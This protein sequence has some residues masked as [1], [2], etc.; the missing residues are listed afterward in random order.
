MLRT[1]ARTTVIVVLAAVVAGGLYLALRSH[2]AP[3]PDLAFQRDYP[4]AF[5]RHGGR[6][7]GDDRWEGPPAERGSHHGRQEASIGRG[8]AGVG[9]TAL[10]LGCIG[11]AVV[12]LQ[13]RSRRR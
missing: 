4:D 7:G 12:W 3:D 8:I 10:Q 5:E 13:R 9:G 2:G 11:A 1:L 6:R